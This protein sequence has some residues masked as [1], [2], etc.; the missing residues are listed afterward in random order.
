MIGIGEGLIRLVASGSIGGSQTW[1]T[2]LWLATGDGVPGPTQAQLDAV[3]TTAEA[4]TRTWANIVK[5]SNCAQWSY[6]KLDGYYYLPNTKVAAM[7]SEKVSASPIVGTGTAVP[8]VTSVVA[9]LRTGVAGRSGRGRIY[10]PATGIALNDHGQLSDTLCA[11]LAAG[12]VELIHSYNSIT[13]P[14]DSLSGKVVVASFTK[15]V[16]ELVTRVIVNSMP[17]VQHRRTNKLGFQTQA[18]IAV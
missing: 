3:V 15:N 1:S 12:T 13:I 8:F 17:D 2:T 9:S 16:G 18:S 11:Q 5:N 6:N 14:F 4:A 7:Q 10:I